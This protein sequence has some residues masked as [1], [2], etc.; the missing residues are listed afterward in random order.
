MKYG[1]LFNSD[2]VAGRDLAGCAQ[3]AEEIGF[4]SIWLPELFGREPFV[5]AGELLS[6]SKEIEVGT[7]IANVYV[8]DALATIAAAQTLRELH[9]DRF[10]L[11]L[12]VSNTVG[13]TMRGHDWQPPVQ[14]LAQFFTAMQDIKP[15]I[16]VSGMP[17]IYLAAHG[18]K[19]LNFAAEHTA[20]AFMYLATSEAITK[21]REILG[22]DKEL[23]LMQ[24][25]MVADSIADARAV[26]R[27]SVSIYTELENYRR[28]W[29]NQGFSDEDFV[30]GPSD[31]LLDSLV[32]M[33]NVDEVRARLAERQTAGAS[34]IVIIA[35]NVTANRQP[36][37]QLLQQLIN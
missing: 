7:A 12:G 27:K 21:G 28:A 18:P 15:S 17:P 31:R 32:A 6:G 14:K 20:G 13:N 23:L 3:H 36:D 33:G 8:R 19:L 5:T 16:N 35:L 26:A 30:D 1:L 24:T 10:N 22:K 2:P 25:C 9:G 4:S 34:Q 29:R 11:G 37:W